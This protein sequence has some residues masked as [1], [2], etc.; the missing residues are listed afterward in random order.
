[1]VHLTMSRCLPMLLLFL[2]LVSACELDDE[3]S[4]GSFCSNI[5][6]TCVPEPNSLG[7]ECQRN[8]QCSSF[9]VWAICVNGTCQC[10]QPYTDRRGSCFCDN[11]AAGTA[12]STLILLYTLVPI[13]IAVAVVVAIVCTL[14]SRGE[15]LDRRSSEAGVRREPM[16]GVS[17]SFSSRTRSISQRATTSTTVRG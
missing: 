9:D 7:Q 15:S 6:K 13:G 2:P 3:C 12:I 8:D 1:M 16:D 10:S 11:S 4:E 14:R 5:S 17:V